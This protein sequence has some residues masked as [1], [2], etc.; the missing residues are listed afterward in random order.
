M[1]RFLVQLTFSMIQKNTVK[2]YFINSLFA[3]SIASYY[4][5]V[6]PFPIRLLWPSSLSFYE[7]E[8]ESKN[9]QSLY[10]G[11]VF[12][13]FPSHSSLL[14]THNLLDPSL[15][16][17]PLPYSSLP[18]AFSEEGESASLLGSEAPSLPSSYVSFMTRYKNSYVS[19]SSTAT[20]SLSREAF[21]VTS[22]PHPLTKGE[23][24]QLNASLDVDLYGSIA[25][26]MEMLPSSSHPSKI[27]LPL[28]LQSSQLV[29][30]PSLEKLPTF[31]H[32]SIE[33]GVTVENLNSVPSDLPVVQRTI[34][35]LGLEGTAVNTPIA[36]LP[37]ESLLHWEQYMLRVK[38]NNPLLK[39]WLMKLAPGGRVKAEEI[40][41]RRALIE[42]LLSDKFQPYINEF[43][44][45]QTVDA[46]IRRLRVD[47]NEAYLVAID[48]AA[49]RF[50]RLFLIKGSKD[51][52]LVD[53]DAYVYAYN[54][55]LKLGVRAYYDEDFPCYSD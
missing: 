44:E 43:W 30:L 36:Q 14:S 13:V 33:T 51:L 9:N 38:W 48:W 52:H 27:S 18:L 2:Y 47:F 28:Q 29:S 8:D 54:F 15:Y 41:F 34:T 4:L 23:G 24:I 12:E 10:E 7:V 32:L 37:Q 3:L 17:D 39:F 42:T 55:P 22:D 53:E 19:T 5:M 49:T 46:K 50:K 35:N 31:S 16:P 20:S 26:G 40:P 25:A 21:R 6:S 11:L 1:H 45:E